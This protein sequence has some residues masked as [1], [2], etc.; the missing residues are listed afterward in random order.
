MKKHNT[1]VVIEDKAFMSILVAA[2]EAFPSKF[3]PNMYR[4]PKGVTKEGEVHGL[5]FGQ[6]IAK[7]DGVVYNV[8]LAVP[9]QIV[10]ERS[11]NGVTVSK[12]HISVIR[13]LIALF[14]SYQLLGYF[15]SHPYPGNEFSKKQSVV[16]SDE[17]VTSALA[18]AKECEEDIVELI[19]GLTCLAQHSTIA[20]EPIGS[21][22]I[23]NCCGHY[24][25]TLAGYLA[26]V[27]HDEES[28]DLA[29]VDNLICAMASGMQQFDFE[30][31]Q[32][33]K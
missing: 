11:P 31:N 25:Y 13:E 29:E 1:T 16:Y 9:N 30:K 22:M 33:F 26:C 5:L 19:F 15:H 28:N 6:R 2:V 10:K 24:K 18:E 7:P 20:P 23:H 4:K 32:I 8:T 3:R 14:P 12:H 21:G 27:D 17:D